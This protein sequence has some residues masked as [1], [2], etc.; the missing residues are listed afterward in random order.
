M[1]FCFVASLSVYQKYS[2]VILVFEETK[3]NV[4][5]KNKNHVYI[6]RVKKSESIFVMIEEEKISNWSHCINHN[7]VRKSKLNNNQFHV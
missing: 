6:L 2:F 5:N 3:N 4:C 7:F 1:L